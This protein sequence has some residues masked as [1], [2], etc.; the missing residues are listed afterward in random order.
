MAWFSQ[1]TNVSP[2]AAEA[3][4]LWDQEAPEPGPGAAVMDLREAFQIQGHGTVFTGWIASG[5]FRPGQPVIVQGKA[6]F[7]R[8]TVGT[9]AIGR[10][11]VSEAPE[12]KYASFNIPNLSVRVEIL[13]LDEGCTITSI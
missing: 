1:G 8:G 13:D 6:G 9:I 2:T 4:L 7:A 10:D 5:T 3:Q 12:G 11:Q